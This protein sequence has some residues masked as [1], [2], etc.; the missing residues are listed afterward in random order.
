M[1]A[2]HKLSS[3]GIPFEG[4]P[5]AFCDCAHPRVE[6][7]RTALERAANHYGC[8]RFERIVYVGDAAWDVRACRELGWPLVGV[9][10]EREAA[11][12]SAL[13]VSE[14]IASY[15]PFVSFLAALERATVPKA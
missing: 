5:M 1:T 8:P 6:I 15:E 12:L 2:R 7:M 4:L 9:G 14:V 13:G 3:A 10:R 11:R